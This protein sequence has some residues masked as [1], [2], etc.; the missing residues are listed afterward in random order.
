MGIWSI[1][2]EFL[3]GLYV[4]KL[5]VEEMMF[6][7]VTNLMVLQ[8]RDFRLLGGS[9]GGFT[10]AAIYVC[11]RAGV[12]ARMQ[13]AMRCVSLEELANASSLVAA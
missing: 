1:N 5:P 6:F 12:R 4:G 2:D 3:L 13:H 9:G 11:L 8:V 10:C 7:V